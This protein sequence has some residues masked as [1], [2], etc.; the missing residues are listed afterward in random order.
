MG[1]EKQLKNG[2]LKP[3][4]IGWPVESGNRPSL[5]KFPQDGADDAA[6]TRQSTIPFQPLL[7]AIAYPQ[8]PPFQT[9]GSKRKVSRIIL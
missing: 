2:C 1:G 8:S 5:P 7:V 3:L 4:C 9:L 6:M